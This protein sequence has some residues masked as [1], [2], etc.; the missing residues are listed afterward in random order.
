MHSARGCV[1][2]LLTLAS[3]WSCGGKSTTT[4][5]SPA[6]SSTATFSLNGKVSGDASAP[7]TGATVS[8]FDGPNAGRS[9]TTDRSGNYSFTALQQSGFTVNTSAANYIPQSRGVTLTS[10]QTLNFSLRPQPAA[11]TLNGQVADAATGGPIAGAVVSINGRYTAATDNSGHF[12]VAGLLDYGSNHDFTYVSAENY[13]PDYR[14]ILGTIQ[15]VRLHR[16]ERIVA[17]GSKLVTIA[18]DDSLCAN[19]VQDAP[20]IQDYVCRR[21]FVV[22]PN[23]GAVTIEAVSTQDGSHPPLEVETVGILPCCSE[24]M[25]NPTTIE[26]AAGTVIVVN[27][28]MLSSSASAQSFVVNTSLSPR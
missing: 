2:L 25:G 17:G 5:P 13:F 16:V 6:T 11:I 28:E 10:N 9:T 20:S 12:S 4:S 24:R 26:V 19:N 21:V 14:H 18:P 23:D 27:V 22:A 1:A 3:T 15:N 8:I 7:I